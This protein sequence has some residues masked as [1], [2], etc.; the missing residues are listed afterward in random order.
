MEDVKSSRDLSLLFRSFFFFFKS[1][2]RKGEK[3]GRKLSGL[4]LRYDG[5]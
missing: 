4:L 5:L 2:F 3:G 1:R